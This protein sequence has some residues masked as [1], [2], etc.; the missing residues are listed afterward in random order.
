MASDT[1][2]EIKGFFQQHLTPVVRW[3]FFIN[4]GV[5]LMQYTVLAAIGWDGKFLY[6]F[7]QNPSLSI[8]RFQVWRFITYMFL[9]GDGMHL[10][11]NMFALWFFAP[12]LEM[13]WGGRNFFKFY[14]VCGIG[15]AI[16]HVIW[17]FIFGKNDM[18]IGASGALY[19][20]LLAYAF[21]W[22]DDTVLMNFFIPMKVKYMVLLFGFVAFINSIGARASGSNISHITHLGGLL[23]AFLY[24]R[25]WRFFKKT[26]FRR[27]QK[28]LVK[29]YYRDANGN[30]YTQIEEE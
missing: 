30:I 12:R 1:I 2:R 6:Y 17:G 15:A 16:V 11:M 22:P 3:I 28:R 9:H 20:I 21:N 13:L 26:F 24:L 10:L 23:T 19:G 27:S 29:R 25:G 14:F 4:V 5:L 7:S 18:M 8:R